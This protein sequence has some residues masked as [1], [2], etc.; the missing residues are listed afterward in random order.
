MTV[1]HRYDRDLFSDDNGLESTVIS[2]SLEALI[3][4]VTDVLLG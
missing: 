4:S 1:E 2:L 3:S